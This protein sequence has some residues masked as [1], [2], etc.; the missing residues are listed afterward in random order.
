MPQLPD[1]H[2]KLHGRDNCETA[3][4][5]LDKEIPLYYDKKICL[6]H[7]WRNRILPELL[8]RFTLALQSELNPSYDPGNEAAVAALLARMNFN[9][10]PNAKPAKSRKQS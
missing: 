10:T 6:D 4:V 3:L 2:L 7:G 9:A 1:S 8:K 5:Y